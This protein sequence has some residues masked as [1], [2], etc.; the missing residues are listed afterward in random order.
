MLTM[1]PLTP[2]SIIAL[3]KDWEQRSTLFTFKSKIAS[4]YAHSISKMDLAPLCSK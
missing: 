1:A 3:A 4:K 2:P